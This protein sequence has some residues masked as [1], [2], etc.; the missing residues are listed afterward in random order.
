MDVHAEAFKEEA[1]ELLTELESSLLELEERPD[2]TEVVG[3]VFR[4]MHTIK[5]SGAM[6]GFDAVSEFTHQVETAFDRVRDGA[7]RVTPELISL[8]LQ[9]RDKILDLLDNGGDGKDEVALQIVADF[10]R[11]CC[12]GEA[13]ESALSAPVT[14]VPPLPPLEEDHRRTFRIRFKPLPSFFA[15]GSNPLPLLNELREMGETTIVAHLDTIPM[16]DEYDPEECYTFWDI[17]LTTAQDENAIRDVFIFV[18]DQCDLSL[19]IIHEEGE[20]GDDEEYKRLGEILVERGDISADTL[21]E[22]IRQQPRLGEKLVQSN[23]VEQS[24]IDA[25]LLEQD[26]IRKI[27]EK[28]QQKDTQKAKA[29]TSIKVDSTRLDNLVDLVGELVTV[30]ARLTQ[31]ADGNQDPDLL[32]IAEE[33]ERLT[34]ELRDNTMSIRMLPIGTTFSKFRRLVRD[35]SRDLGKQIEMSTEG[36]ET[37]LDKTVIDQLNDPLVHI[38]RNSIDHGVE[39]PEVRL[40][41]GKDREGRIHLAAHHSGAFVLIEITDNGAG[42][43]PEKLRAKAISKGLI[44][45]DADLSVEECYALIL[46]PGFSTAEKVTDVSGRGVGMDVVKRSIENLRG[47]IG[48]SSQL[49][50]GTTIT[51]KLPLTLAIIDGLLVRISEEFFVIPLS[52]VEE[53]IEL[54]REEALLAKKRSMMSFRGELFSYVSLR[55]VFTI[56]G[57]PPTIER[58]VLANVKGEKTGFGVDQVIGQHQTVIKTLSNIYRGVTGISGATILGDGTVALVL[59][60]NQ[61]VLE[62]THSGQ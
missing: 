20:L 25:A 52:M 61:L 39:S 40:A 11:L 62:A 55:D 18:E 24:R 47:E 17:I 19:D 14:A 30:Q 35:L 56:P 38:I 32:L 34:T 9:A 45:A 41:K 28:E 36:A 31:K 60:V 2:D 6:F 29:V 15:N 7:I 8:T 16:L 53:C 33:V 3:R 26:H 27:R 37:E 58:V 1:Y 49:G 21:N 44:A 13:G 42:L 50:V 10:Q 57:E 4:A 23:A 5:G 22:I 48:I 59:D 54:S 51:L 43:D 12:C 46:E